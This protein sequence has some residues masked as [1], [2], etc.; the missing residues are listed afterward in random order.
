MSLNALGLASLI[1]TPTS[2]GLMALFLSSRNLK[3]A[4][5]N[6]GLNPPEKRSKF[7]KLDCSVFVLVS[8]GFKDRWTA[9]VQGLLYNQL[10]VNLIVPNRSLALFTGEHLVKEHFEYA[11]KRGRMSQQEVGMAMQLLSCWEVLDLERCLKKNCSG[12]GS[13]VVINMCPGMFLGHEIVMKKIGGHF[14]KVKSKWVWFLR[15][16]CG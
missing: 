10:S 16:L 2:K 3:S 12:V 8:D 9:F 7:A 1:V 4:A 6:F 11:L 15:E 13:A 14:D 5:I